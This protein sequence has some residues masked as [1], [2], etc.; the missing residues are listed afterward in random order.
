PGYRHAGYREAARS[1]ASPHC[2]RRFL[3]NTRRRPRTDG[4]AWRQA[5]PPSIRRGP[6]NRGVGGGVGPRSELRKRAMK[7]RLST[8]RFLRKTKGAAI[9]EFALVVPILFLL[10]WGIISFTRAYQR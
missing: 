2:A 10:V 1:G 7:K 9:V 5:P 8:K 6:C 3:T 4:G